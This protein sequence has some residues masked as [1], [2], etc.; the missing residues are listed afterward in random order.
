[1]KS[2]NEK[3]SSSKHSEHMN[4][5]KKSSMPMK[6][7]KAHKAKVGHAKKSK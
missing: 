1:M 3:M 5:E 6:D 7:N 4:K 2:K